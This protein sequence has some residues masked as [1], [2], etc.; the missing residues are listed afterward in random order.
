MVIIYLINMEVLNMETGAILLIGLLVLAAIIII[1]V[2]LVSR[3][4]K[5]KK[6]KDA[7]KLRLAEEADR[8]TFINVLPF[9]A[10]RVISHNKTYFAFNSSAKQF[11]IGGSE[12]NTNNI[13]AFNDFISYELIENGKVISDASGNAIAGAVLF[14]VAGA[15]VGSS[16]KN[17]RT[18]CGT[19]QLRI[20]VNNITSP[21]VAVELITNPYTLKGSE[22]YN[23]AMAFVKEVTATLDVIKNQKQ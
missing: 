22:R 4:D 7:E 8:A 12:I 2:V 5:K 17:E 21:I 10:D 11:Y 15:V 19:M 18:V 14:G 20:I 6:I 13:I 23:K 3:H 9:A 16:M 1:P